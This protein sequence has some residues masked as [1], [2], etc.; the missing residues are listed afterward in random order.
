MAVYKM[1]NG[2]KAAQGIL[3]NLDTVVDSSCRGKRSG[4][5]N[6]AEYSARIVRPA[7]SAAADSV[8]FPDPPGPTTRIA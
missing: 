3:G 8:D 1:G 7:L 6:P 2:R 5:I 4:K